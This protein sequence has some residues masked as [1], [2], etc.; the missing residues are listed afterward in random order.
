MS[1][2]LVAASVGSSVGCGFCLVE[3]CCFCG[4]DLF[5]RSRDRAIWLFSRFLFADLVTSLCHLTVRWL[6]AVSTHVL[7]LSSPGGFATWLS[8]SWVVAFVLFVF[9]FQLVLS[10]H[11]LGF[12][13]NLLF[14]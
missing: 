11:S 1:G 3:I 9:N 6:V 5:G 12:V 8:F 7:G 4:W 10:A 2:V 14:Y 13:C